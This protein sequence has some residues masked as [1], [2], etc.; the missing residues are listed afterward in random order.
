MNMAW[1][2]IDGWN[3]VFQIKI[4]LILRVKNHLQL[5]SEEN[6]FSSIN[7]CCVPVCSGQSKSS[8]SV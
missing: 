6:F 2:A 4:R 5:C 3:Q 1:I 7:N 8:Y